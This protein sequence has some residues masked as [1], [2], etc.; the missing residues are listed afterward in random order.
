MQ[1]L[2]TLTARE[3]MLGLKSFLALY[4]KTNIHICLKTFS[5]LSRGWERRT[6]Q[7]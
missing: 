7:R 2:E 5:K 4:K 3:R 1:S 6:D